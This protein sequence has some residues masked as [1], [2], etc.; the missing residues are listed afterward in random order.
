MTE[1]QIGVVGVLVVH[2]SA[3]G[4]RVLALRRAGGV[5]SP[6]SWEMVHGS[7]DR[8]EKPAEAAV[9]ELREETGLEADRL[10]NVTVNTFHLHA[11][12][13]IQVELVFCAFVGGSDPAAPPTVRLGE[14]HDAH[15]WLPV[16][17]ASARFY[18]PADRRSLSDAH[19]LLRDGHAG[20]G[21]DVLRII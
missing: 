15:E 8:G 19:E 13:T 1:L 21:E 3:D 6:G 2:L 20:A 9:R 17:A 7:L 5:R 18:W 10:Y 11:N 14:E 12:D 4:W 16:A